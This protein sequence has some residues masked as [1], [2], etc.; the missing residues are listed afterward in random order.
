MMTTPHLPLGTTKPVQPSSHE[1]GANRILART[2]LVVDD[3]NTT[4]FLLSR[5]VADLGHR[6]ITA[7]NG[8]V[9]LELL[10]REP[11]DLVLLDIEMPE[12][13]GV[14]VLEQMKADAAL[15][16][17]PVIMVSGV[18]RPLVRHPLYHA[19]SRGLP[20]QTVRSG[21][22]GCS[23]EHCLEKKRLRDAERRKTREL[24]QALEQLRKTQVQLVTQEK[25]ASLGALT[26]GIAHEIKN[27]LNFVTNFA[28]LSVQLAA[29][30]RS[31]PAGRR[32][33]DAGGRR[34]AG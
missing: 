22:A 12:M 3:D 31:D 21:P 9:A 30:L 8:R 24:E 23:S 20:P 16:G 28:Q 11:V 32:A 33:A 19:G 34:V 13:D 7:E 1:S 17:I 18:E 14:A 10:R 6:V 29:E 15:T 5:R 4:R 25:L 2:V 26:A 27:P